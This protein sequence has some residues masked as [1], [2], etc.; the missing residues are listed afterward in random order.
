MAMTA[1]IKRAWL[2][3]QSTNWTTSS[4]DRSEYR[5]RASPSGRQSSPG[6]EVC[7]QGN[8]AVK[9]RTADTGP[10]LVSLG[11]GRLSTNIT[12][13]HIP[14]GEL[15]AHHIGDTLETAHT[16]P[17]NDTNETP[18]SEGA[19]LG[20]PSA[21]PAPPAVFYKMNIIHQTLLDDDA[22]IS[23]INEEVSRH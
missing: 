8:N 21:G 2:S 11:S 17:S 16:R 5:H 19:G 4:I 12:L 18:F 9:V 6:V 20:H 7:D 15:Y 23:S 13:I 10:H 3:N 14:E 22:T 1:S